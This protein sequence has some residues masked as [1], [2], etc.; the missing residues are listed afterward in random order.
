MVKSARGSMELIEKRL[1]ERIGRERLESL[2]EI[3]TQDWG[4]T[5]IELP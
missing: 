5:D 2:A 3:S 1:E 4:S